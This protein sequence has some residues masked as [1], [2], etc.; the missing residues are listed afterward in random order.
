MSTI[1]SSCALVGFRSSLSDGTA[2][3]STVRSIAYTTHASARTASPIHSRRP[4]SGG[5]PPPVRGAHGPA[6]DRKSNPAR[7]TR[8]HLEPTRVDVLVRDPVPQEVE[9]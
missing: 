9:H 2:R 8:P 3:C 7:H 6:P 1:Q 5:A 4:A